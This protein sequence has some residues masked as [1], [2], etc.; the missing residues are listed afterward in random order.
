MVERVL[1]REKFHV[2]CARDGAEAIE[3]LS[4]QSYSTVLLDMMMPRVDGLGVI[5]FLDE[6][7]PDAAGSIIV[8]TANLQYAAGAFCRKK[9]RI[10]PKPFDIRNLI[11]HVHES[12]GSN[13]EPVG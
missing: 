10:I 4:E 1:R 13:E 2:D 12:L 3:K 5:R 7:K 6:E 11:E 9:L 8:M